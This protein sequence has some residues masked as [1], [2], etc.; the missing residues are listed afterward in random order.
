MTTSIE[1]LRAEDPM[2]GSAYS[3][4][5]LDA[6]LEQ[7]FATA[8]KERA[9]FHWRLGRRSA[10]TASIAIAIGGGAFA[11]A[12]ILGSGHPPPV[13]GVGYSYAAPP[14]GVMP[15]I[16]ASQATQIYLREEVA[17]NGPG[18]TG[19]PDSVTLVELSAPSSPVGPISGRL[20][21]LVQF[22]H[23]PVTLFGPG[24]GVSRTGT[25]DGV[26]DATS[27]AFLSIYNTSDS[28]QP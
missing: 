21:W 6:M 2:V 26:V 9:G 8:R 12:A 17:H 15:A 4:I 11:G 23:S 18:P 20:V 3:P 10:V 24:D 25:W 28:Q 1:Q 13:T 7:A 27:G 16:T 19:T 22:D 14:G 5:N